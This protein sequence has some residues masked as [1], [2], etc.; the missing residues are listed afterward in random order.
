MRTFQKCAVA[1]SLAGLIGAGTA[2]AEPVAV[3]LADYAFNFPA[4][5]YEIIV[6]GETGDFREKATNDFIYIRDGGYTVWARTDRLGRADRQKFLAFYNANCQQR[7]KCAITA[8][9][10]VELNDELKMIF[11]IHAAE[12]AKDGNALAVGSP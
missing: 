11:R 4:H 10:E 12:L 1:A 6:T 8:T 3:S 2:H 5:G 9:G 7:A